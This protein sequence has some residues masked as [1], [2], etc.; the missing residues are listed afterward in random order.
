MCDFVRLIFF[1]CFSPVAVSLVCP[2]YLIEFSGGSTKK[3]KPES[4][5]GKD[6]ETL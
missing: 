3:E 1:V 5:G 6:T 2:T 4:C